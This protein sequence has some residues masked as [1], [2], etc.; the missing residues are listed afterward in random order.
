MRPG[1]SPIRRGL[2]VLVTLADWACYGVLGLMA[3]VVCVEVLCRWLLGFSIQIAEETASLGLVSLTCLSLAGAFRDG[4]FL[5]VDALYSVFPHPFR[6]GLQPVF[7]LAGVAVTLIYLWQL[8]RLAA[9]SFFRGIR[10]DTALGV[11]NW[12]PQAVMI[13]GLAVLLIVIVSSFVIS[14]GEE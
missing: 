8:I 6:A 10:S 3:L 13:A 12:I 5:R 1:P 14:G 2:D 4:H 7:L 9:D 11:L